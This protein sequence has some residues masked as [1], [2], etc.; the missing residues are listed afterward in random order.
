MRKKRWIKILPLQEKC[1]LQ[2]DRFRPEN[3]DYI[4]FYNVIFKDIEKIK[5]D[6]GTIKNPYKLTND[7]FKDMFD[8]SLYERFR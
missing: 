3:V 2:Y 7:S 8:F 5:T 1:F 6:D 4:D